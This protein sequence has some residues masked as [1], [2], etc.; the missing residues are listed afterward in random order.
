MFRCSWTA[1]SGTRVS[2]SEL[3][4]AHL[5]KETLS[6][7]DQILGLAPFVDCPNPSS[8]DLT[9]FR[10][11]VTPETFANVSVSL[12]HDGSA[13]PWK[14]LP[15][16]NAFLFGLS[17]PP[18]PPVAPPPM[19]PVSGMCD[20]LEGRGCLQQG[21]TGQY[22]KCISSNPPQCTAC[23]GPSITYGTGTSYS[24]PGYPYKHAGIDTK[25][26]CTQLGPTSL[27]LALTP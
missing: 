15:G 1:A 2:T 23:N 18:A 8:A 6:G 22:T 4:E 25:A 12:S 19:E 5:L 24:G 26:W 21:T 10:Q 7:T 14:G 27:A 11:L 13:L 17:D 3:L 16:G 9:A 20:C